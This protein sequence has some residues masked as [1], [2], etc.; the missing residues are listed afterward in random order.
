MQRSFNRRDFLRRGAAILGGLTLSASL[1]IA[2]LAES[3]PSIEAARRWYAL[4]PT[5]EHA[6]NA[7]RLHAANKLFADPKAAD[8]H[9]AHPGCKCQV[10]V[11]GELPEHVW[12]GLFGDH[13]RVARAQVDRRW[14]WVAKTLA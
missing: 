11:G 7:C 10:V 3:D 8:Q 9:R 14:N 1:P 6:D 13:R 2:A 4:V 12:S 5:R